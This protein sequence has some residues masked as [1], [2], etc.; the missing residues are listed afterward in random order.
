MSGGGKET[1]RQKMIG[2]MYLVL[3]ALL[4][5]NISKDVLLAFVTI[6]ENLNETNHIFD[7][8]NELLYKTFEAEMANDAVKT[9]PLKEK[10]DKIKKEAAALCKFIDKCEADI[11]VVTE[12]GA[13]T[14][15]QADTFKLQNCS[16]KDNYDIPTHYLIGEVESPTG[17]GVELKKKIEDFRKLCLASVPDKE[18]KTFKLGLVTE[19]V[20]DHH[21]EKKVPWEVFNFNHTTIAASMALLA[22][23][24]N[25]IKVAE[26]DVV[27]ALL[28][29]ITAEIL[30]FDAVEAKVVAPTSYIM[31][32]EKYEADI[33]V[34]AH[35]S[36][37]N[38][39]ITVGGSNVNVEGG[40]GKYVVSTSAEGLKE[41]KGVIKVKGPDGSVKDYP[42]EGAY[43]VAKPAM[44]VSPT[45]M[46][47]FYIGVDNPVD[48]TVAGA[49]PTDV[50][51]TLTG[52]TGSINPL[53]QGHYIVKVSPG[54]PKCMINV[55]IKTKG[56]SSK[57]MGSMEFRVKKVPS[58]L[59][60]FA[61]ITGDGSA[62]KG[63]LEAALGVVPKLDDFVFD[64]KFPV[65]SWVM[66]M[67]INGVFVDEKATGYQVTGNMKS[68]L[69]RAKVNSKILI[70]QV[71]V[72]APDGIRKVPGC[73]IKV[74]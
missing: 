45:K 9:K 30:R 70:E 38:P 50:V 68:M 44:A 74:K 71:Q 3:T 18:K 40:V 25:E 47:V 42:F 34:S 11:F 60:S 63:E 57:S 24:K 16:Q 52:A 20:Y 12:G 48:I 69:A 58:P 66:S 26:S 13:L 7:E 28:K 17:K 67:N 51:A 43:M 21:A 2:M 65:I 27:N 19:D 36:T 39:I 59:A 35:S 29:Q 46:N 49:A 55:A 5:M 6:E 23:I 15:Q 31:A 61:G 22:S 54:S 72:Q 4:A 64:L 62:S 14:E 41:Y 1:P 10:A 37:Q 73:V 33:F 8:K 56:G 32:G 53:G